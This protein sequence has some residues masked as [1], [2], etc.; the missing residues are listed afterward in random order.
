MKER[1]WREKR[2]LGRAE[3]I[4][5][6]QYRGHRKRCRS[7]SIP[8]EEKQ[9]LRGIGEREL[10]PPGSQWNQ[11]GG[12]VMAKRESMRK[13]LHK[14]HSLIASQLVPTIEGGTFSG[15]L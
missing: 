9:A 8:A 2:S 4:V 3:D 15:T 11:N 10:G 14:R 12:R 5:R 1:G 6:R 7:Y 13:F